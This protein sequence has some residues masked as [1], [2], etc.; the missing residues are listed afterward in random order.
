MALE[1]PLIKIDEERRLIIGRA[2]CEEKDKSSE[3]LDYV[4]AKPAF[5]KWSDGIAELSGGLSKGNLRA[6]HQKTVAGKVIN[7]DYNDAQKSI[8]VIAHVVDDN[9]WNLVKT[10]CYTGFSI[11]GGYARKWQDPN[12]ATLTRYT[13]DI[14]ELSLVDTP[15]I[16]SARFAELIKADGMT[17]QL[18]LRG[19]LPGFADR[20]SARP[21]S[22][23]EQWNERPRT[24]A[25]LRKA[26][27][28]K[29]AG[30]PDGGQF[31]SD[32]GGD[33]PAIASPP[34]TGA[35][36]LGLMRGAVAGGAIGATAGAVSLN[37]HLSRLKALDPMLHLSITSHPDFL[38]GAFKGLKRKSLI[39]AAVGIGAGLLFP[40]RS[41]S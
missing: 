3:I 30:N 29:P 26:V 2:A 5:Q 37:H 13:P 23:G 41:G 4:T 18:E 7:L 34:A 22:F 25:Q 19:V 6:M 15:C 33:S 38:R 9:T 1:I 12:D 31:A 20:W 39:G 35:S 10:G 28:H 11:G 32:G 40:R 21:R 14:R 8:D 24:F 36:G 16:P 17:M 27:T